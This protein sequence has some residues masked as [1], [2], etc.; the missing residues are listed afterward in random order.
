MAVAYWV[1]IASIDSKKLLM[2]YRRRVDEEL[3]NEYMKDTIGH[4]HLNK[5]RYA[6]VI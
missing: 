1:K 2:D 6:K 5:K 4:K 3:L